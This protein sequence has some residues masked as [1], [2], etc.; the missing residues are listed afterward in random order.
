MLHKKQKDKT[1]NIWSWNNEKKSAK[2]ANVYCRRN[3][4][5]SIHPVC[6]TQRQVEIN[7]FSNA[8]GILLIRD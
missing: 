2:Y 6:H 1:Q 3:K 4:F 5:H 8:N 7:D